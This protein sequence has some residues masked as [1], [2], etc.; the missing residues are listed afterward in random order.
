MNAHD[1]IRFT[2]DMA[3]QVSTAYLNDLT[4]AEL[5]HRPGAGC[6]HINW[7][8]GH[9]ICAENEIINGAVPG[10]L[11]P[12]PP[13]FVERY[14]PEKSKLDDPAAFCTK[15][16]L[17]KVQQGQREATLAALAKLSP[18]D[19]DRKLEGW[20]P[21]V[22]AAF[23]GAAGGHWLMHVGQWAIVRRQ[24]GRPPLF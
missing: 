14:K 21:N 5:L 10:A 16:E 2:I 9:L 11:P 6:N 7:Q 22:G 20:T 3:S 1:V 8:V 12:L 13:Q 4:D 24:L 19:L 17:L 23:N 15:A 18:T